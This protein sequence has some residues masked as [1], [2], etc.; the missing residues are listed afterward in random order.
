MWSVVD[1]WHGRG[2]TDTADLQ[3]NEPKSKTD[4]YLNPN[5]NLILNKSEMKYRLAGQ[6]Y[7]LFK[8][9]WTEWQKCMKGNQR[10]HS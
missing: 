7:S 10:G 1:F 8:L 4:P 2:C 5:H 9:A 3:N 6:E